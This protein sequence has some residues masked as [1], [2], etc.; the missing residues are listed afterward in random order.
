MLNRATFTGRVFIVKM[1][2]QHEDHACA[3]HTVGF[4]KGLDNH[5]MHRSGDVMVPMLQIQKQ[6][7]PGHGSPALRGADSAYGLQ[8]LVPGKGSTALRATDLGVVRQ[9]LVPGQSSTIL[10]GAHLHGGPH[11]TQLRLDR[12]VLGI[13]GSQSPSC[14]AS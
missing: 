8:S 11:R 1:R 3:M 10:C 5:N 14:G 13:L 2:H 9:V 4:I 12:S 6:L 7:A